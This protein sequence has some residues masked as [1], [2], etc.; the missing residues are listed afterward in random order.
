[1]PAQFPPTIAKRINRDA[2]L[3]IIR[4]IRYLYTRNSLADGPDADLWS[5]WIEGRLCTFRKPRAACAAAM[6]R[7][8]A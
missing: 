7:H 2:D 8:A 6:E 5:L 1:M 3:Y 4:G